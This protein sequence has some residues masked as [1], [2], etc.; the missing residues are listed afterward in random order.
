MGD[1]SMFVSKDCGAFGIIEIAEVEGAVCKL[2][3]LFVISTFDDCTELEV[4]FSL[5]L[6]S[7]EDVL[8]PG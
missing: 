5:T 1:S 4:A 7:D 8:G 6:D 2:L 3:S